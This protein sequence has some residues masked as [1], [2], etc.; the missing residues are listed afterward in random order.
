MRSEGELD[1]GQRIPGVESVRRRIVK[2]LG[3]AMLLMLAFGAGALYANEK[4]AHVNDAAHALRKCNLSQTYAPSFSLSGFTG[5]R[6]TYEQIV[7][8]VDEGQKTALM[9]EIG[10]ATG[11]TAGAVTAEDFRAFS[12]ACWFR[13]FPPIPDDMV[14][15]AWF[16]RETHEPTDY[17]HMATG[18]LSSIGAIGYGFEFAVFDM[19]TGLMIFIDQFG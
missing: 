2:L 10:H 19:E 13:E 12:K 8:A 6:D 9:Q 14:F 18:S 15:D 3:I 11:W 17:A 16:Y 7:F 1:V 4:A 5:F